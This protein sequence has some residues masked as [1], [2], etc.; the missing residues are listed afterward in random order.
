MG[1]HLC[2]A[3]NQSNSGYHWGTW[4]QLPLACSVTCG[5]GLRC[6]VRKCLDGYGKVEPSLEK[7][8]NPEDYDSKAEYC[9]VCVVNVRCPNLPGWGNWGAWSACIP[10][11]PKVRH[12][13]DRCQRGTRV[14]HRKCDNPPPEFPPLG[15]PCSGPSKQTAECRYKCDNKPFSDPTNL[16]KQIELLVEQDHRTGLKSFKQVQRR[17]VGEHTTMS[18]D[19]PAYRLAKRLTVTTVFNAARHGLHPEQ[20]QITWFK[21]GNP[22]QV[23]GSELGGKNTYFT[24]WN[25]VRSKNLRHP[26]LAEQN[27]W[28]SLLSSSTPFIDGS[29]LIF[30]HILEG[31]HGFY[32]CELRLGER[33]WTTIFYSLIVTGISYSA[34]DTDPFYLHSNL[35]FTNALKDA[36]VWLE[37]SHVVWRLNGLIYSRGL[38]TRGSRR[39]QLIEH[40]NQTHSGWWSC[41]L[42]IPAT[43][44]TSR[45]SSPFVRV[46]S[47][48]LLNELRL[49]VDSTTNKLWLVAEYPASMRLLR[50]VSVT[51]GLLC[52][53]LLLI[54]LLT[55]WTSNRWLDRTLSTE[56]KSLIL[57]EMVDNGTRLIL[58][59]RRRTMIHRLRLLPLIIQE[60]IR[61]R[62][63]HN[64]LMDKLVDQ[65][66]DTEEE[67]SD[68][69]DSK[70]FLQR[71][72]IFRRSTMFKNFKRQSSVFHRSRKQN[73]SVVSTD[74][75]MF[76][77]TTAQR[78]TKL[79]KLFGFGRNE[80]EIKYDQPPPAVEMV[81]GKYDKLWSSGVPQPDNNDIYRFN[82]PS[83]ADL[84]ARTSET[85]SVHKERF[86]LRLSFAK[87]TRRNSNE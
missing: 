58:T 86:N 62:Q 52:E 78:T 5:S 51:C 30:P 43:G 42:I 25:K 61:L 55:I 64:H 54:L 57:E 66:D 79:K 77:I 65:E 17:K 60:S 16:E 76:N 73:Y 9:T 15:V 28:E 35:G 29:D 85:A 33:R 71:I 82:V 46:A 12:S 75:G 49:N 68:E 40:L 72:S 59:A 36:P 48:Y 23:R 56:Q 53:L 50:H 19:T 8:R 24:K 69:A 13:L 47:S 20:L 10:N 39:I 45:V 44:P 38:V 84:E 4:S 67:S 41:H 32:S 18:C 80:A 22:V 74:S 83:Y 81:R 6:R 27:R 1:F 7:C 34:H 87:F 31:D 21:N 63:A 70:G 11:E 37:A 26:L 3:Y 14:R 2:H